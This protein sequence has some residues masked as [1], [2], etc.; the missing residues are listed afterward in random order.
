MRD[1]EL[2]LF[3]DN[4]T[5]E[6]VFY[7]GTLSNRKLFNLILQLQWLK[8]KGDLVLHLIHMAGTPMKDQGIDGLSRGDLLEGV[9]KGNDFLSYIP[10]HHSACECSPDLAAWL[11]EMF[12]DG[13]PLEFLSPND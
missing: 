11:K 13:D 12:G 4:S 9:I 1:T 5:V 2:F 8:M 10:I 6:A 3:T 7:R